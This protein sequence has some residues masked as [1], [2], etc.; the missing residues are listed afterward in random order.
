MRRGKKRPDEAESM[1]STRED[2]RS[3]LLNAIGLKV[4]LAVLAAMPA[5]RADRLMAEPGGRLDGE[6]GSEP[7]SSSKTSGEDVEWACE[8]I[9]PQTAVILLACMSASTFIPARHLIRTSGS[10]VK[11]DSFK[12][13]P[14]KRSSKV[15]IT[16]LGVEFSHMWDQ[17]LAT[18]SRD[19][20]QQLLQLIQL[21]EYA[22]VRWL[23]GLSSS[24]EQ[25][26]RGEV[27][28]FL[29][30]LAHSRFGLLRFAH[31]AISQL[32]KMM[33]FSGDVGHEG[34]RFPGIPASFRPLIQTD[35]ADHALKPYSDL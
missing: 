15:T 23:F 30:G 35:D 17:H 9:T 24:W 11:A 20:R 33:A 12:S 32:S 4:S 6:K 3:F 1:R 14:F 5:S 7:G 26:S 16:P 27:E 22:P 10:N 8:H 21:L 29:T 25:A 13:D 18:M 34:W 28:A 2:R 19:H 31:V